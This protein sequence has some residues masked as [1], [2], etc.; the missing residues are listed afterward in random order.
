VHAIHYVIKYVTDL[1]QVGG[2]LMV[3]RFHKKKKKKKKKIKVLPPITLIVTKLDIYVFITITELMPLLVIL[4][5]TV[6][7]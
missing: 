5:L 4:H 7:E 2:C 6:P 1:Q 3:I